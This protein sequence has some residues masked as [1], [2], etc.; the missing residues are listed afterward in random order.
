MRRTL[1]P[2]AA[3]FGMKAM[4]QG[5]AGLVLGNRFLKRREEEIREY[6]G[7]RHVFLVSSGKAAL[8]LLLRALRRISPEKREVL[9]PA[10]TC[11]SV[12]AAVAKAGL[13]VALCDV[14]PATFDF[15]YRRLENA[16]NNATLCVVPSHL[17]GI[18]SDM[19]R[20]NDLCRRRGLF[21]VEDAAQAMGGD[22][23][24]RRLGTL[25]DAGFF[26]LGRGKNVTCGS[27]G[28]IVTG[29]AR[30]AGVLSDAYASLRK[31]GA[32]EELKEYC[33]LLL[34]CLFLRPSLYWLPAGL[35]FLG[36]GETRYP[37]EFPV[38]RLSG[39]RAGVLAGWR[40]RLEQ[41]NAGR[42]DTTR[43]LSLHL[44]A[45]ASKGAPPLLRFPLLTGSGRAR[46]ALCSTSRERGLGISRMYP[47]P[48]NEI[49][50]L[51]EQFSGKT[52]PSAKRIAE[53]LVTL[54]T[55]PLLT[56]RDREALCSLIGESLSARPGGMQE[57]CR[58][59]QDGK[60]GLHA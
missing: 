13:K 9:I 12:P 4:L 56:A 46:E 19:D 16:V 28:I 60:G 2:A 18:P 54:P 30:I 27:G 41:G 15:D 29:S 35:P 17:F 47:C 38:Q 11:F 34:L 31:P 6:F 8:T 51:R 44:S 52:F 42:M 21:V 24:G 59:M 22:Y 20:I 57:K 25:G 26:S 43:F 3:P 5:I 10:Y 33:M 45:V 14:D 50:A 58:A 48:V 53:T 39:M 55:H 36:L 37:G 7:V 49:G 32:A 1:P 23:R 40:E